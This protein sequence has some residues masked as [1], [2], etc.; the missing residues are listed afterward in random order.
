M[1][2]SIQRARLVAPT[3]L[4]VAGLAVLIGL[5]TWQ[6]QRKVWKEHVMSALATRSASTAIA[7]T[8]D[9]PGLPC[10]DA[11]T[12]A[13]QNPCEYQPVSL[14]GTFDHTRERHIFTA[15][16]DAAKIAPGGRGYWVFTPLHLEGSNKT[17]F[18]NRGYVPEELKDPQKRVLGQTSQ[19][20]EVAG[21][22]RSA[23]ERSWFDGANDPAR[24]IWYVR[25]PAEMWPVDPADPVLDEHWA[26]VDMTGPEPA[27]GWP[28][29]IADQV[30]ISNRHLE[31]ALTW[32][33]LA[34]TLAVIFVGFARGRLKAGAAPGANATGTT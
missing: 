23:Q 12:T 6:M 30:R 8:H 22:Y 31:Y 21:L 16:P 14:R 4:T 11:K 34:A 17:V 27:G 28:K 13:T 24:N 1:T 5:G 3:L 20:I 2:T 25:A 18:V 32:Y 26:Y 7:A 29:P 19:T 33:A 10:F 9:W 15:A